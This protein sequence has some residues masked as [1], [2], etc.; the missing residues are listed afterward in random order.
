VGVVSTI[1]AIHPAPT[2]FDGD[3][4]RAFALRLMLLGNK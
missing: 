2:F 1:D 4:G 3:G